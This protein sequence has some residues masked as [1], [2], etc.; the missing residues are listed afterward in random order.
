M[1]QPPGLRSFRHLGPMQRDLFEAAVVAATGARLAYG[2]LSHSRA[3][4]HRHC[5]TAGRLAQACMC[6]H[7]T[8]KLMIAWLSLQTGLQRCSRLQR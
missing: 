3:G 7:Q 5:S 6:L 1:P 2:L 4:E 8:W